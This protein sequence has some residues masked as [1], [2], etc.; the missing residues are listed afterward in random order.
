MVDKYLPKIV[1]MVEGT[2]ARRE[3]EQLHVSQSI[4]TETVEKTAAR[5]EADRLRTSRAHTEETAGE[6]AARQEE[7]SASDGCCKGRLET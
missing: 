5:R 1:F 2:A 6:A 7:R 3:A 4:S